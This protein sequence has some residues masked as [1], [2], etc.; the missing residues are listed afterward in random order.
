[1]A[2]NIWAD[3]FG[4]CLIWPQSACVFECIYL[5]PVLEHNIPELLGIIPLVVCREIW[6]RYGRAP[7]H[8]GTDAPE[9]VNR[10]FPRRWICRGGQ[11]VWPASSLDLTPPDLFLWSHLAKN[12]QETPIG[13]QGELLVK[14]ITVF[15]S[16]CQH[17]G[18]FEL[19]IQAI[20]RSWTLHIEV[21]CHH[22]EQLLSEL[23]HLLS[24]L[25]LPYPVSTSVSG[26][27][28]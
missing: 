24:V 14:I 9:Y 5:P 8:F 26:V 19:I 4:N 23:A 20:F 13:I 3:I 25:K 18:V 22:F 16:I 15:D 11:N 10:I 2:V 7:T 21:G 1:M 17:T 12:V 28:R 6:D 27:L